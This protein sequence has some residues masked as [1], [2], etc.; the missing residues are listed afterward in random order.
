MVD[1]AA[2]N[3]GSIGRGA[4]PAIMLSLIAVVSA[5]SSLNLAAPSIAQDLKATQTQ[6]AW[7][8]DAYALVFAALLLLAG[9]IGDRYGRRLA[10]IAGL[11]TFSI[12]AIVARLVQQP[13]QLIAAQA[14]LGVGAAL[15]MPATLSTITATF[16]PDKRVRAVGTWAGVSG[17]SAMLGLLACGLLLE[18]WSWRSVFAFNLTM[19]IVALLLTLRFVPES[20]DPTAPR[21]DVVGAML[22]VLGLGLLVYSIIEAPTEGW[23][24]TR[25]LAGL[26]GGLVVLAGFM[27]WEL[28]GPDPLLDPRLFK[29]RGFSAGTL[30]VTMQFFGFFGFVFL[31]AQ[32]L[33]LV[34]GYSALVSALAVAPLGIVMMPAARGVAP[35]AALKAGTMKVVALGLLLIAAGFVILAQLDATSSYWVLL[36]GLVVLGAG[37][38]LA[39]TPSTG[40]ITDALPVAKQGVGSAVNDLAREL[41]AALGIAVL[42]S[43][44]LSAYRDQ[45][46]PV[47]LPPAVVEQ[48]RSSLGLA[49]HIG[50][51]VA[52]Q[53]QAAFTAGMHNALLW[54]A[55]LLALTAVA[56]AALLAGRGTRPAP[57]PVPADSEPAAA[58]T[59]DR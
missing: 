17:A 41:G 52:T 42:G 51:P 8:V 36:A 10:L 53:A 28:T 12:G 58:A 56:V 25:T 1:Q 43:I 29:L 15:V 6:I 33:Q 27:V 32:Y 4:M 23:T 20:A 13:E 3:R 55:G 7:I 37:M 14:V 21:L 47:G 39:M 11:S 24:A 38:G 46:N 57:H 54:A 45:L 9:A 48:A 31:V 44:M 5:V 34:L 49:T 50:G 35:R 22:S 30:T 40:A 59:S 18:V 19:G 16:P 2:A 26:I